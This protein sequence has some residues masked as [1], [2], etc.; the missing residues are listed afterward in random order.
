M[1]MLRESTHIIV[2]IIQHTSNTM[3]YSARSFA[4]S[5][6]QMNRHKKTGYNSRFL[7]LSRSYCFSMIYRSSLSRFIL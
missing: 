3:T 1:G 2:C 7:K 5:Y 4:A 6:I